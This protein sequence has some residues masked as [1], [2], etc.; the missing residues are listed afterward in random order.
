LRDYSGGIDKTHLLRGL[1]NIP[2]EASAGETS[3]PFFL[4]DVHRPH[5]RKIN[6][7]AAFTSA[8]ARQTVTS[9]PDRGQ[10]IHF[11]GRLN[12]RLDVRYSIATGDQ[13]GVASD[14]T[15][16]NAA[17]LQIAV[18]ARAQQIAFKFGPE[19]GVDFIGG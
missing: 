2:K 12:G 15:V 19:R 4:I 8:K 3:A 5:S 1:I 7:H 16:P 17:R 13:P 6:D 14:R 10:Q 18:S 11:A 9:A